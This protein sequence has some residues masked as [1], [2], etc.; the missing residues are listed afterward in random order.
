M[1]VGILHNMDNITYYHS[2]G[3]E[4]KATNVLVYDSY[5]LRQLRSKVVQT[6]ELRVIPSSTVWRIRHLKLHRKWKR[7]SQGGVVRE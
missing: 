1:Y 7:G 6:P 2:L 5:S 3:V 4:R